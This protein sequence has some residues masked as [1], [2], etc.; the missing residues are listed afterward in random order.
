M[1]YDSNQAAFLDG[2][3]VF[4][5]ATLSRCAWLAAL[6]CKVHSRDCWPGVPLGG[7]RVLLLVVITV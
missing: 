1:I 6:P 5:M 7:I 3:L 4:S 2:I